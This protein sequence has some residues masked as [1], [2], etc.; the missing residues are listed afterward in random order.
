MFMENTYWR[1][2]LVARAA[3][4]AVDSSLPEPLAVLRAVESSLAVQPEKKRTQAGLIW[5]MVVIR[6]R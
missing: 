2:W 3:L 1:G 5:L 4:Q 6:L